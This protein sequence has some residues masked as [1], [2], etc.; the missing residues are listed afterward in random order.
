MGGAKLS[1][2]TSSVFSAGVEIIWNLFLFSMCSVFSNSVTSSLKISY[3]EAG[4]ICLKIIG[5][6]KYLEVRG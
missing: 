1:F 4:I 2:G 3:L 6:S 5:K